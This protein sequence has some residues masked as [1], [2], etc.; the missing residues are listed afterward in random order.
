[1]HTSNA[2]AAFAAL[3]RG[4]S[5][6]LLPNAWDAG[7]AVIF[8]S[9][10]AKAIATT[11]AGLAWSRGFPDGD[12]LPVENLLFA[13]DEIREAIGDLPLSVDVEGGYS[14]D[15]TQVADTVGRL[16]DVGV[17]GINIE[18]GGRDPA[19]LAAKIEAICRRCPGLFVNAR[20]DVYLRELAAGDAAV[21]ESVERGKRY[22]AAGAGGLFVP[23]ATA[24]NELEAIAKGVD[25]PLAIFAMPG[26]P[27]ASKLYAAGVR[28]LSAG[29]SLAALAYGAARD[30]AAAFLRD[31]SSDAV[32]TPRNVEY[33]ATNALF[34][35]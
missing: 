3:H 9:L 8:R 21:R 20:T 28:R 13:V 1:V 23:G 33:G 5:V 25:L 2:A 7:S 19:H 12:A 26:L 22:A 34:R 15:P 27:R 10:G 4:E 14:H 29:E 11:S 6:L 31:G 16:F 18:D 17:A 30:A 32:I 24:L 35:R